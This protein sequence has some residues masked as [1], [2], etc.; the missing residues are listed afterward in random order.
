MHR[1]PSDVPP[2]IDIG[3]KDREIS[4][5]PDASARRVPRE[6]SSRSFKRTTSITVALLSSARGGV[7]DVAAWSGAARGIV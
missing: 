3:P 5:R 7:P 1:R 6:P 4:P 2:P